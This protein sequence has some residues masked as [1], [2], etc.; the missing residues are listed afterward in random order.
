MAY[1]EIWLRR[2]RVTASLL[3]CTVLLDI[4]GTAPVVPDSSAA[5][6]DPASA[7]MSPQARAYLDHALDLLQRYSIARDHTD[8]SD[9]RK[10]IYPFASGAQRTADTYRAIQTAARFLDKHSS[11]EPPAMVRAKQAPPTSDLPVPTGQVEPGRLGLL[12]LPERALGANLGDRQYVQ[13]GRDAVE[14][15]DRA[16]VCGWI[17]DLRGNPGGSMDPMVAAVAPLLGDGPLGRF[18]DPDGTA[19][20]S[21]GI[22]GGELQ[23]DG[24]TESFGTTSYRL[25]L[26]NPPVAVLT[27]GRTASAAEAT[28]ISFHDRPRTR[29]F[30]APTG[31]YPSGNIVLPLSDGARLVITSTAEADRTGHRYDPDRPLLPDQ[32]TPPEEADTAARTWLA[33]QPACASVT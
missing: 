26:P 10:W 24:R 20:H 15:L 27:D 13:A 4:A 30:G 18:I 25:R 7:A 8:W 22:N 32:P 33:Q 14:R 23:R 16:G 11:L 2:I 31:G 17:V 29:F 1:T 5:T 19:D 12:V 21:W 28:V 6:S 9:L 3:L